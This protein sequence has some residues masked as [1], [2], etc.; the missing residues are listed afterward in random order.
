MN[1]DQ[2]K[3]ARDL[4][5]QARNKKHVVLI[6]PVGKPVPDQGMHALVEKKHLQG[7]PRCRVTLLYGFYIHPDIF[8]NHIPRP[9]QYTLEF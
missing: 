5:D 4:R 9:P 2:G 3:E 1:L 8:Q 6:K 7:A